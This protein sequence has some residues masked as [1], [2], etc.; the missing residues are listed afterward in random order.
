VR[1][2]RVG[3]KMRIKNKTYLQ[4]G[5]EDRCKNKKC[6]KC[7]RRIRVSLSLTLAEQVAVE[8]FAMCDLKMF[9]EE[10]PK[11][12]DLIQDVM[13]NVMRK[14]FKAERSKK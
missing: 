5:Y 13:R 7:P 9:M 12:M 14:M 4:C 1:N 10:K 11:E 3:I 6:L 2:I 8:D